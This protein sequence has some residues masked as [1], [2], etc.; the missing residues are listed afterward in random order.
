M[1]ATFVQLILS[2]IDDFVS[3]SGLSGYP[4]VNLLMYILTIS[5]NAEYIFFYGEISPQA[6]ST[7]PHPHV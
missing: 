5:V 6:K 3:V 4:P 1:N 7:N 2:V